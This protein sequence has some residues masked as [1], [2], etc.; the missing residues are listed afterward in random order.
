MR[1]SAGVEKKKEE[2][3]HPLSTLGCCQGAAKRHP[4]EL[5][6]PTALI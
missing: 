2:G 1:G 6:A 4:Q 3:R 5:G